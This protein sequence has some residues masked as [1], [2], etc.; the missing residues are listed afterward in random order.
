[1]PVLEL[2]NVARAALLGARMVILDAEPS[3]E[4]RAGYVLRKQMRVLREAFWE[5]NVAVRL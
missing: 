2:R 5:L 4:T 3:A 1:M